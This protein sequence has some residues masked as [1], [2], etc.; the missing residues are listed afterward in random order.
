MK[1]LI[2]CEESQDVCKEFR[3]LGHEAYSNDIIECSGGHH[4]WHLQMDCMEAIKS[5][6]WDLI[7]MHPPCTKITVSGNSTYGEGKD[8][9]GERLNAVDWTQQ[10]WNFAISVCDK[11]AMEN[12]VGTLNRYGTFPKPSYIQPFQFGHTEQKKTGLWL[13]GLPPLAETENVYHEMMLLPKRERERLHYLPPSKDRA[14]LRS[15]TFAG[16]AKAMAE[17]WGGICE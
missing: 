15:K 4:E 2:A 5:R 14:R 10:L 17:Q 13:H 3:K 1:V 9:H 11:V 16:I 6:K 8:R 12:P 7:I